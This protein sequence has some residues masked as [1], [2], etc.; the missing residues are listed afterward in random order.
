[1]Y[2]GHKATAADFLRFL[3]SDG[4]QRAF[5]TQGYLTPVLSALYDDPVLVAQLPYLTVLKS[6]MQNANA[7]PITPLYAAVSKAVQDNA[8]AAITGS[9][10]VETALSDMT[11]AI[12]SARA[13]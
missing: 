13:Q 7:L 10:P 12:D 8:F 5:A 2:S 6:S 4:Q 1:M 9:K 11:K 3:T